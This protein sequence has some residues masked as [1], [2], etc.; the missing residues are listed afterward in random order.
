MVEG[1]YHPVHR[2]EGLDGGSQLRLVP[3]LCGLA[4]L[5]STRP[6]VPIEGRGAVWP[7]LHG[8]T[9]AGHEELPGRILDPRCEGS[10]GLGGQ[11]LP[12]QLPEALGDQVHGLPGAAPGPLKEG[13]EGTCVTSIH[14][15]EGLSVPTGLCGVP[16]EQLFVRERVEVRCGAGR[17]RVQAGIRGG[18]PGVSEISGQ[19]SVRG[20]GVRTAADLLAVHERE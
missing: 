12:V 16:G 10:S 17:R 9:E 14:G 15:R 20:L 7:A 13:E 18:S 8:P 2:L 3:G 6:L 1:Q 4:L 11:P 5:R 19:G